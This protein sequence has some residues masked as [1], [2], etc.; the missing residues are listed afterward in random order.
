MKTERIPSMPCREALDLIQKA[1]GVKRNRAYEVRPEEVVSAAFYRA[2][3][4][5]GTGEG[6]RLESDFWEGLAGQAERVATEAIETVTQRAALIEAKIE[7]LRTRLT[8]DDQQRKFDQTLAQLQQAHHR[9]RGK[10]ASYFIGKSLLTPDMV[11]R[12]GLVTVPHLAIEKESRLQFVAGI[13]LTEAQNRRLKEQG[14]KVE[15]EQP[16][17]PKVTFEASRLTPKWF[18]MILDISDGQPLE[19]QAARWLHDHIPFSWLK[20]PLFNLA[21]RL[22]TPVRVKAFAGIVREVANKLNHQK[23]TQVQAELAPGITWEMVYCDAAAQLLKEQVYTS[24]EQIAESLLKDPLLFRLSPEGLIWK[25]LQLPETKSPPEG[26]QLWNATTQLL[27]TGAHLADIILSDQGRALGWE[28]TEVRHNSV[29]TTT[30]R[31]ERQT[32]SQAKTYVITTDDQRPGFVLGWHAEDR[33]QAGV[34]SFGITERN[35][36]RTIIIKRDGMEIQILISKKPQEIGETAAK[37]LYYVLSRRQ[38]AGGE[39]FKLDYVVNSHQGIA[40][41]RYESLF[42]M[43]PPDANHILDNSQKTGMIQDSMPVVS[44]LWQVL[45]QLEKTATGVNQR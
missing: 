36:S 6:E 1:T 13:S 37:L 15:P 34:T 16:L 3:G 32:G 30:R 4:D 29:K 43:T 2:T 31:F 17:V 11:D 44:L 9:S 33:T 24:P 25:D 22:S 41:Y 28:Q 26:T 38:S 19:V 18:N 12:Q 5:L 45:N 40:G 8:T 39:R 21:E 10:L 42:L 20:L 23:G 14:T 7:A 35:G 27:R